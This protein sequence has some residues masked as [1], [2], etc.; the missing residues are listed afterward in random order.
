LFSVA[1]DAEAIGEG[2][3]ADVADIALQVA[4]AKYAARCGDSVRGN[5]KAI[6]IQGIGSGYGQAVYDAVRI[7]ATGSCRCSSVEVH[8]C[9]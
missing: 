9:S 8:T 6:Q 4:F 3:I 2:R 5:S 7:Q 1:Q